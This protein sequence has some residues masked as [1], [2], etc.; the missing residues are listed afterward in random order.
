MLSLR[1]SVDQR[2][3]P[4][5]RLEQP[6]RAR[7]AAIA[8]DRAGI[9]PGQADRAV[10]DRRQHSIEIERRADRL[11][12]FGQRLQLLDRM[13]QFVGA[14]AQLVQQPRVLDR[15]HRLVG[16]VFE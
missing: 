5:D 1:T 14:R 12:H 15:D 7:G 9:G 11:P 6:E 13:R 10:E 3:V 4:A 2:L 16:E 8:E